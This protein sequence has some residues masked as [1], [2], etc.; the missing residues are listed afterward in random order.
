M[1][2]SV[3]NGGALCPSFHVCGFSLIEILIVITIIAILAGISIPIYKKNQLK[4]KV[5]SY[6]LPLVKACAHDAA[7]ECTSLR[8]QNDTPLNISTLKN[9]V[10]TVVSHGS[11]T[12]S[13]TGSII[14]STAGYV[15]DG[16][17][18]GTLGGITDYQARCEFINNGILCSVI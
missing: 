17:V 2:S 16:A 10:S 12:I 13:I 15:R 11:L 4:S 6:A 1:Y 3:K 8:L 5:S 18:F 7:A 14:C 9:C